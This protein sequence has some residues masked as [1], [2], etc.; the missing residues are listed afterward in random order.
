[1]TSKLFSWLMLFAL[2]CNLN[3]L[4][5]QNPGDT[6]WV[7]AFTYGSP[8]NAWF[9]F[10]PDSISFEKILMLY[11]L[12]C[13]PAQNPNCGEW[14]Y[15]TYNYLYDHT[16]LLDSNLLQQ[17]SYVVNGASPDSFAYVTTPTYSFEAHV[18]SYTVRSDTV[19][20]QTT[21]IG[22]GNTTSDECLGTSAVDGIS[23]Y[24]WKGSELLAAGLDSGMITGLQLYV[25]T[26][27][28]SLHHFKVQIQKTGLDS[29]TTDNM[30]TSGFTKVYEFEQ[31]LQPGVN[32]LVLTTPFLWDDTS[33]LIISF[34]F[35]NDEPG[36]DNTLAAD[37]T[38]WPSGVYAKENDYFLDFEGADYVD[39]PA[40]AFANI[41]SQITIAFWQYG[42]PDIQPQNDYLFEGFDAD[43]HRV[44]NVHLPWGNGQVYWDAGNTGTSYDRINGTTAA[45]N[46]E[47]Q[48]NYWAFVK[49]VHTGL[50]QVYL[51]GQIL[52]QG[53][54]KFED[55]TGIT[56]FRIG[57]NGNGGGNYDGYIN[58]FSIW[59]KALGQ[60]DVQVLMSKDIDNTNPNYANLQAYYQFNEGTGYTASDASGHGL[61]G[62]LLG[63]P[64]WLSLFNEENLRNWKNTSLRPRVTF[65]Q[66]EFT[67]TIATVVVVDTTENAP[68]SLV[69]YQNPSDPT[70]ATDTQ[71]VWVPNYN[72]YQFDNQGNATDS[73]AVSPDNTV[74]LSHLPYY[75][76][77]YEKIDRYELGRFI[78]PYG[79]GL[80]LGNGFTW[81]YDVTD[82]RPLLAD[83]VHLAAGNWQ[84]LLDMKFMFIYGTPTRDVVQIN[85]VYPNNNYALS[86]FDQTVTEQTLPLNPDAKSWRLKTRTSGHGW[87]NATNCAEFCPKTHEVW[88]DGAL[89]SQW[90]LWADC[91]FNPVYPQGGTWLIDRGGWCPGAPVKTYNH[92]LTPYITPQSDSVTLDYNA[93]A[94]QYGNYILEVQLVQYKEPNFGLD[95]AVTDIIA[96]SDQG[97][98]NRY[99]PICDQPIIKIKNNGTTRLTQCDITYGVVGGPTWYYTWTGSLEFTEET[100]VQLPPFDWGN[101][102][103][104]DTNFYVNVDF[105]NAY[106]DDYLPNNTMTSHF[107][108]VPMY[109]SVLVVQ[110]RTNLQP[111]EN[112][113]EIRNDNDSVLYTR[114]GFP[115]NTLN[116]DTFHLAPGCYNFIL[117]DTDEDGLSFFAN[118]DG[119]GF[120]R[121]RPLVGSNF[122]NFEPDFGERIEQR[123]TVGYRHGN[124]P[125][126]TPPDKPVRVIDTTSGIRPIRDDSYQFKLYPNPNSGNFSIECSYDKASD[127]N[128]TVFNSLGL[129]VYTR[130]YNN[131]SSNILHVGLP[132]LPEGIYLVSI[133]SQYGVQ[134]R[135]LL[136][137]REE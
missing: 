6:L 12:K 114:S 107:E 103:S 11:T 44:L 111:Q 10:P 43:G 58:E 64:N 91:G 50:M 46:Y 42:D 106:V 18:D 112:Y 3:T 31:V 67:S 4:K 2:V 108:K 90:S 16:G 105:P 136:I 130:T 22:V 76:T 122:A 81:V 78:T 127:I 33:N 19:S 28:S 89:V 132:D 40:A 135:R 124:G 17:P 65:E 36:S 69:M 26:P 99:N 38:P 32:P 88:C 97:L 8:Q 92:E 13:N 115:A 121:L 137:T 7:Q 86:T 70:T 34:E 128:L 57:S 119:N 98:Y 102:D 47:G 87:D 73:M 23:R 126:L 83:S 21:T 27:G 113:Y 15:L 133:H 80:D 125:Y 95:V 61:D 35:D 45:T 41:D 120:A 84:E 104:L 5:A 117:Y 9:E 77:S 79:I 68:V 134:T 55:M 60:S 93:E 63:A 85:N 37:L 52:F 39:I 71:W 131:V 129:E 100:L 72:N 56:R 62:G 116:W 24:L 30:P 20:I 29:L 94:D 123:F 75:G 14:D 59:N 49:N 1:M 54:N 66:G 48:W 110:L 25:T 53:V 82:Y 118:S 51:N 96:P 109:D 101:L 74:Y